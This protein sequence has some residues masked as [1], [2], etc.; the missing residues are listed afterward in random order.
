MENLGL[1]INRLRTKS[2]VR[3]AII[4]NLK[5]FYEGA[6]D[7]DVIVEGGTVQ[8]YIHE[9]ELEVV[10][11]ARRLSDGTLNWLALLA[12]LLDPDPP[13]LICIDEPELGLHPDIIPT[14]GK[15]LRDA[16]ERTQL[17]VTTHSTALVDE[18]TDTPE[19]VVVCE[20]ENGSTKF[21]RLESDRL[22]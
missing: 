18:F 6:E 13:P 9:S 11:P 15:L 3:Q 1:V 7:I 5:N 17:I 16:S 19:A 10:V 2:K 4:E 21:T 22:T 12:I 14:L 20:K 8:L